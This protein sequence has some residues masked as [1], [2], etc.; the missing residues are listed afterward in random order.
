MMKTIFGSA[1]SQEGARWAAPSA[2]K[3]FEEFKE[4]KR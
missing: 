3:F 2:V 1:I 4:L